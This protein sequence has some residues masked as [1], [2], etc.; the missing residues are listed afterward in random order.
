[1][2]NHGATLSCLFAAALCCGAA[3][4]QAQ[5]GATDLMGRNGQFTV[6]DATGKIETVDTKKLDLQREL[7]PSAP[8]AAITDSDDNTNVDQP[9][10]KKAPAKPGA[11]ADE[12]STAP[13]DETPEEKAARA[14]DVEALRAMR[15]QGG[16]YFYTEDDKPVPF[17]EIDRRIETGEVEG[18]KA[19]GLHLEEWK[20]KTKSKES[21]AQESGP[22]P[23]PAPASA[24]KDKKKY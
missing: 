14:E 11:A 17:D 3:A 15:K 9:G 6:K 23:N 24:P 22:A 20:P 10:E 4:A 16:A 19:V 8:R 21:A 2:T 18:L 1:M 12:Q 7:L 5:A 13:K